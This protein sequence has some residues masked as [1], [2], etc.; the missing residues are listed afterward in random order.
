[1]FY[2]L[3]NKLYF[4]INKQIVPIDLSFFHL[5]SENYNLLS[6]QIINNQEY[7]F[8]VFETRVRGNLHNRSNVS[9]LFYPLNF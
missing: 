2:F 5:K 9:D 7:F 6:T 4:K 8:V 3:E 1:M